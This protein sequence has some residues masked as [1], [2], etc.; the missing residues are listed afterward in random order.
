MSLEGI[1]SAARQI[2]EL[3]SKGEDIPRWLVLSLFDNMGEAIATP[4]LEYLMKRLA[5]VDEEHECRALVE[6]CVYWTED[7]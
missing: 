4:R 3:A 6:L 7:T 5:T 1:K 2:L